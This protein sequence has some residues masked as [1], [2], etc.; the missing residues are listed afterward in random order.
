MDR[1][2]YVLYG[3]SK[4]EFTVP[5]AN[6]MQVIEP[7]RI[8]AYD[9][10]Q[11]IL[12]ALRHPI[13]SPTLRELTERVKK[14]LIIANDITRPM[15]SRLTIPLMIGEFY[16]APEDYEITILIATGLHRKMTDSEISE[17][18]GDELTSKYPIVNHVAT[19]DSSLVHFG[20]MPSGNELYLNQLV[21]QSELV[22]AEGFIEPHF[23]AGFSGGRKAI[24]PGVAGASTIMNNHSPRNIASPFASIANLQNNPIH[25]EC[26]EA[27]RLSGL[28]FILNVALNMEKQVIAAFAGSPFEAH[29]KGCEYVRGKMT[30]PCER[31]DIVITSNNGYPLDRNLYQAVKGMDA[32]AKAVKPGGVIIIAAEC[33]DGAGHHGFTDLI[34]GCS[35]V[36]ELYEKMS[37]GE[38]QH[39]KWQAQVLAR[40]LKD[41]TV[42]L[43]SNGLTKELTQRMFMQPAKDMD[44]ALRI[45]FGKMGES[46]T[47]NVLP[48]GP[49]V[50]PTAI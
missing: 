45:A 35:S 5:S 44:D 7:A 34:T 21:A 46:A 36:V 11:T 31:A 3:K 17:R 14:V 10:K 38:P 23:F 6:L 13:G 8:Q 24:L 12:D 27:A 48:E 43:V 26:V 40:I 42:V 47:V 28:K 37:M 4:L 49:V 32:A 2:F 20:R 29:E 41:Y 22:I 1:A 16:R 25:L 39:D 19:D 33:M 15:P 50:V 9:E 30:V 18:F